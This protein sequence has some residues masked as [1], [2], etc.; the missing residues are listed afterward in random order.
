MIEHLKS[1]P[2]EQQVGQFFC[3]GIGGPEIDVSTRDLLSEVSPGGVCLFARN[4]REATQTRE[5]LDQL[6]SQSLVTPMLSIDQEGGLVDRLRRIMTPMPAANSIKTP[7]EAEKL[8]SIIAET[9]LILGFNTNFAPVVDVIDEERAKHPNGLFSR[10]FGRSS[11]DVV[12]LAGA[13]IGKLQ[14]GGIL[15]CVKHFPGLGAAQVDSHEELPQVAVTEEEFRSTELFPYRELF[16]SGGVKAVMA[17]HAVFPRL[18]LQETDK[19][20]KLLPSSLS[21]N[22]ITKLLC[23]ELGFSGLVITDD[24]EMGAIVKNYGIGDACKMAINA[25][26]DMLAICADRERIREGFNSVLA[27]TRNGEISS[28]RL[29]QSLSRIAAFK[30]L[31]APPLPFDPNRLEQLSRETSDLNDCLRRD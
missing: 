20:G 6:R 28:T 14:Q 31:F 24:L 10:E 2:I 22:L 29:E 27:A 7:G 19:N 9:L 4:I 5:L 23:D 25:G 17:A 26:A 3:I 8:A 18:G 30:T 16:R 21:F 15:G 1:L 12:E 11:T 13:Y